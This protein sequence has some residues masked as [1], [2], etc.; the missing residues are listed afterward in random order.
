MWLLYILQK[1]VDKK[2]D[3]L[4]LKILPKT[5]EEKVIVSFE[6]SRFID[7]RRLLSSSSYNLTL[8][9]TENKHKPPKIFEKE[10]PDTGTRLNKS[11]QLQFLRSNRKMKKNRLK[12]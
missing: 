11:K 4:D 10:S 2:N 3:S 8:S 6:C 1:L 5:S 7:S 9:F 12:F